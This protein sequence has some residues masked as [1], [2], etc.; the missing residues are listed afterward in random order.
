MSTNKEK[1]ASYNN[2]EILKNAIANQESIEFY[3]LDNCIYNSINKR[4]NL[5]FLFNSSLFF[6]SQIAIYSIFKYFVHLTEDLITAFSTLLENKQFNDKQQLLNDHIVFGLYIVFS[7][8]LD[9]L[10]GF[11]NISLENNDSYSLS[12]LKENEIFDKIK[13]IRIK[14]QK[15]RREIEKLYL[16]RLNYEEY[17]AISKEL[18]SDISFQ[19][20]NLPNNEDY[21]FE[22]YQ[23]D[24]SFYHNTEQFIIDNSLSLVKPLEE[25][26]NQIGQIIEK[27]EYFIEVIKNNTPNIANI[28]LA[29]IIK[30]FPLFKNHY[31]LLKDEVIQERTDSL[32]WVKSTIS[33]TEYFSLIYQESNYLG[34]NNQNNKNDRIPWSVLE[35][36]FDKKDLKNSYSSSKKKPSKDFVQIKKLL[37]M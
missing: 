2:L 33:L 16:D 34:K 30:D 32:F 27:E 17:I 1:I 10:F 8:I 21:T 6:K 4:A 26:L 28:L 18:K 24:K 9:F 7:T 13:K 5:F 37:K 25:N 3:Y 14:Y 15:E 20:T 23:R 31:K 12:Q 36:V 11:T 19:H 29:Q 22:I 35:R